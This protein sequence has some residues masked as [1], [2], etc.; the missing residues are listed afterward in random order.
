M[1]KEDE[2][3]AK[4]HKAVVLANKDQIEKMKP[5]IASRWVNEWM[6]EVGDSITDPE[7]FR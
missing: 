1:K 6:A 3:L 5:K 4:Y 2:F 7:E